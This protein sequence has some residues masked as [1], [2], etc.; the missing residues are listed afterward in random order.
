MGN[1]LTIL[2]A[3]RIISFL[4]YSFDKI[5]RRG[6]AKPPKAEAATVEGRKPQRELMLFLLP[7][8]L[9]QFLLPC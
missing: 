6:A 1:I 3:L 2:Y 4:N 8:K 9:E 5:G 7:D